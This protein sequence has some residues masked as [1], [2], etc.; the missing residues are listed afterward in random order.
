M[1]SLRQLHN[2]LIHVSYNKNYIITKLSTNRCY[3]WTRSRILS[4]LS[5]LQAVVY[6]SRQIKWTLLLQHKISVGELLLRA[7]V[8]F[9]SLRSMLTFCT[10]Y[11]S[12][13][14]MSLFTYWR[15]VAGNWASDVTQGS[16]VDYRSLIWRTS[17]RIYLLTWS[18][19]AG[20]LRTVDHTQRHTAA[21]RQTDRHTGML[22]AWLT[23]TRSEKF[24]LAA[25]RRLCT[26]PNSCGNLLRV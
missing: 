17:E 26:H 7:I 1:F 5:G 2:K 23:L 4:M 12:D 21:D 14:I 9:L 19:T 13:I 18:D 16:S 25:W 6:T 11:A 10:H 3:F 8:L 20:G 24:N 22:S 15:V